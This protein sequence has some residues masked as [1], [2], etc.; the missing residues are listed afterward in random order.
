MSRG[1]LEPGEKAFPFSKRRETVHTNSAVDGPSDLSGN[2]ITEIHRITIKGKNTISKPLLVDRIHPREKV[3]ANLFILKQT[4]WSPKGFASGFRSTQLYY[5]AKAQNKH[6]YIS[7]GT[8]NHR[9][10]CVE[11][12][13][14]LPYPPGVSSLLYASF[15]I[16][17]V[18]LSDLL[19]FIFRFRCMTFFLCLMTGI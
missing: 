10:R 6:I 15:F 9:A 1:G 2:Y 17:F 7:L 8:E 16:A 11:H 4:C 12:L 19:F 5:R 14:L 3:A 13:C 18:Y